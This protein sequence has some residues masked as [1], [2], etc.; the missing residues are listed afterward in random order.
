V[1]D[2][3]LKQEI[4]EAHAVI[5][6][7]PIVAILPTALDRRIENS[8]TLGEKWMQ[9]KQISASHRQHTTRADQRDADV[10]HSTPA[11]SLE[12]LW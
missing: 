1:T 9:G 5:H 10:S 6:R 12:L 8:I 4:G 11:D 7:Q 2:G 3:V